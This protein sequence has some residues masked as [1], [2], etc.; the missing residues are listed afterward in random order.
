VLTELQV[1]DLSIED[2]PL[3]NVIDQLYRDGL[4]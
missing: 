1:V 3:E 4:P 2:P